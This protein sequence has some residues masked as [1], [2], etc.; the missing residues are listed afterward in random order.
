MTIF[1]TSLIFSTECTIGMVEEEARGLGIYGGK[2]LNFCSEI[3]VL[4]HLLLHESYNMRGVNVLP[5]PK[6][7]ST[8]YGL[9]CFSYYAA[10]QWHMLPDDIRTLA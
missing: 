2:I 1:Q 6:V 4:Y 5:L 3:E 8:K 9:K 7:N 10:K